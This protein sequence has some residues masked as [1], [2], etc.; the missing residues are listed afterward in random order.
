MSHHQPTNQIT[1]QST[2]EPFDQPSNRPINQSTTRPTNRIIQSTNQ[3]TNQRIDQQ[4][5]HP[6][7]QCRPKRSRVTVHKYFAHEWSCQ[8][9]PTF[10]SLQCHQR[11]LLLHEGLGAPKKST[12]P[13]IATNILLKLQ[14]LDSASPPP[15][16]KRVPGTVG[17]TK[18]RSAA[19]LYTHGTT[20]ADE[21]TVHLLYILFSHR[22]HQ[23]ECKETTCP[24][25]R[26][27]AAIKLGYNISTYRQPNKNIQCRYF[28]DI[29]HKPS[30]DIFFE[31]FPRMLKNT[32]NTEILFIA[33]YAMDRWTGCFHPIPWHP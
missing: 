30:V 29:L 19:I 17:K 20:K 8:Q 2:N 11:K 28:L 9:T 31:F 5:N 6:I 21:Y 13:G 3:S 24:C 10:V 18:T 23:D 4:P 32:K 33:L 1:N 27:P 22:H 14:W 7:N 16:R 12:T 15:Q 26:D 25:T